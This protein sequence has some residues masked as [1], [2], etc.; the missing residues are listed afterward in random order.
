[1]AITE[2]DLEMYAARVRVHFPP[3]L[4]DTAF[5]MAYSIARIVGPKAKALRPDTTLD[6][7]IEWVGPHYALEGEDSMD[8]V[9]TIMAMEVDLGDAFVLP[10]EMAARSDTATFSELV[11]YVAA[12]KRRARS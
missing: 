11:Q 5:E 12:E 4:R 10:D 1:M 2:A 8:K 7:L 6:E 3:E 9:E